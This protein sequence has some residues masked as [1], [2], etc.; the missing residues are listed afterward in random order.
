M[1]FVQLS[2]TMQAQKARIALLYFPLVSMVLENFDKLHKL[3]EEV[4]TTD[5]PVMDPYSFDS[6]TLLSASTTTEDVQG[7]KSPALGRRS[8]CQGRRSPAAGSLR[9]ESTVHSCY[10]IKLVLALLRR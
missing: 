1:S 10:R 2:V 9:G 5:S 4:E 6:L 8:P 3:E 7:R